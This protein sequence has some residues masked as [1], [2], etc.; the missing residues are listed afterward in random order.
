M[1][2]FMYYDVILGAS[3][4]MLRTDTPFEMETSYLAQASL[5]LAM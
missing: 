2:K 1:P 3:L 4:E 5:V